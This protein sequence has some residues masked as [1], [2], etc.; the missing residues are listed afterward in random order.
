MMK[1]KVNQLTATSICGTDISSSCLFISALAL[2]Y[3]GLYTWI[4]LLLVSFILFVFKK[5]YG[6][7]LAA[8][9]LNGGAYYALLNTTKKSTASFAASLTVLDYLAT[10]VIS[11]SEAIKYLSSSWVEIPIIFIFIFHLTSLVIL[12][13][14]C[15]YFIFNN[16]LEILITTF[17]T[18]ANGNIT[19]ALCFGFTLATPGING[20]QSSANYAEEQEKFV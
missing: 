17:K 3:A 18:H 10:A 12:C 14:F 4:S 7:V 15:I 8:L 5:I 20:F 13:F 19:N 1:K 11:A 2:V 9:P 16:R 6:D